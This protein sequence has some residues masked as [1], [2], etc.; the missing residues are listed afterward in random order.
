LP[1]TGRQWQ[2]ESERQ[3]TVAI[4][5][6]RDAHVLNDPSVQRLLV[7]LTPG[8]VQG[9]TSHGRRLR[10][11]EKN[12]VWDVPFIILG[13][14]WPACRE[15]VRQLAAQGFS[16]FR[17]NNLGHFPLFDGLEG[18]T[19]I[20]S[21]RLFTLNS[22]AALA[23]QELG[24]EE[25]TLYLEDDRSNLQ[26]LLRRDFGLRRGLTVYGQ[27]P[28]IISRIPIR[29]VRPDQP[30]LSDRGDA[31]RVQTRAGLTVLSS[32]TDFSLVGR[33]RELQQEG[34]ARFTVDLS[35]LGPFSKQGKEVMDAVRR[36]NVVSGTSAFNY[37]K[38]LE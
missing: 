27:V 6:L 10:G 14:D 25:V 16:T 13:A 20:G 9:L 15:R 18:V 5:D 19:L 34:C 22:Q 7:P 21:Y 2:S 1:E 30:V 11:R 3:I 33:L 12:V 37:D 31:Y 29:N 32:E 24:L 8:T 35:H 26:A 28:L 38:S 23:W 17:L 4:R 36:D